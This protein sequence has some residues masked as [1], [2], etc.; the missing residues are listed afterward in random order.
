MQ[1]DADRIEARVM[2]DGVL[3][4]LPISQLVIGDVV[5]LQAG[6]RVPADGVLLSGTVYVDQSALNGESKEIR[7]QPQRAASTRWDLSNRGQLFRGSIITS[8]EGVLQVGRV[9]SQTF[10][11]DMAQQMQ[12]ETLSLIHI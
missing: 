2:R 8:G 6:E 10:Y 5:R 11:G 9:G 1:E 3:I 12:E 4:S 7:K